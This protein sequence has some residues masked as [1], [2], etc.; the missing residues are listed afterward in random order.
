MTPEQRYARLVAAVRAYDNALRLY[1]A[2]S[3]GSQW[4]Q[5]VPA[6]DELWNAVLDAAGIDPA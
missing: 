4:V 5:D 3:T 2:M 6:L 1:G